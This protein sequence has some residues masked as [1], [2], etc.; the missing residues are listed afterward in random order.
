MTD[1]MTKDMVI[2]VVNGVLR[3]H[4]GCVPLEITNRIVEALIQRQVIEVDSD[5]LKVCEHCLMAIE[6]R[7]GHQPILSI[8]DAAFIDEDAEFKCDWCG[9]TE[10]DKL[11]KI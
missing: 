10:I 3:D 11:Y 2:D 9:E 6:S 7:E 1:K 5:H 4:I 8:I